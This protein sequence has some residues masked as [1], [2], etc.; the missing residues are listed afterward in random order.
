[1]LHRIFQIEKL[2]ENLRQESIPLRY[3]PRCFVRHPEH[4]YFYTAESENNILAPATKQKLLEDPAVI[5]GDA[6]ILPPEDFGYPRGKS[7]W[8]SCISVVDPVTE[9]RVLQ[10]IDLE[11]NEAAVSMAAVSFASQDGESFLIVGTGKDMVVSPRSSTSGF[12]HVY[13]FHDDGKELEFIHKTQISEPPMALLGFQGRLLAGV[14]KEIIIYDLG[15]KQLLR[16][17]RSEVVPNL[18][19]GLQTQGNRIVVSDVQESVV[20]VVF[21]FQESRLIPFVDDTISRFTSCTTMVDYETVAGGDKFGNFWLVR[22]P[23]KAS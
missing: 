23:P 21:K 20:M 4:P 11:D 14:G 7:H 15:V 6:T 3:T 2:T 17:A 9:K 18:V 10:S 16:K 1:M 22:C 19:V 12:L 5:N 13:R 8:A